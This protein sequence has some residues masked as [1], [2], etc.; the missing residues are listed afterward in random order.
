MARRLSI[1][2]VLAGALAALGAGPYRVQTAN[3]VVEAASPQVAQE[4]AQYAEVYRK[5]KAIQW[6]GREMPTWPAP[7]PVRVTVQVNGA[8]GATRR[9]SR[10]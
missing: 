6:L 4:V 9:R 10:R 7:C 1:P 3:F 5:E 8:G 2:L